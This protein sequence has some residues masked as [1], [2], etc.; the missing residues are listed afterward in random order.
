VGNHAQL[1]PTRKQNTPSA[2]RKEELAKD[3]VV[4]EELAG[5]VDGDAALL[6]HL[7]KVVSGV[8]KSQS[9]NTSWAFPFFLIILFHY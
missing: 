4:G 1:N 2:R 8:S 9:A 7:Y 5:G 6:P 3:R